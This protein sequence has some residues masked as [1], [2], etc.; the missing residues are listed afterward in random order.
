[1]EQIKIIKTGEL[2]YSN[3]LGGTGPLV[4][5]AG[6]VWIYRFLSWL[7]FGTENVPLGQAFFGWLYVGTL[8]IVF[9]IYLRLDVPPWVIY[10]LVLSKRLH[11]I[12]VLRLFNDCFTTFFMVLTVVSL[13]HAS[14]YRQQNKRLARILTNQVSAV[15]FG[16]AISIKMNALLYLPGFCVVVYFLN[17]EVLIRALV[18]LVVVGLVQVL[19]SWNFLF[20]GSEIRDSYIANAFDFK[21][22]F[23]YEWT[24]NWR[25]FSA[26]IFNSNTFHRALLGIHVVL[27]ILF[28][29]NK[30]AAPYCSGKSNKS[31]ITDLFKIFKPTISPNHVIN[32]PTSGPIYVVGVMASCNLIG[33]LCSRSL[34][35]QFLS[36]YSWSFPYLLYLSN[37]PWFLSIAVFILHEW[38]W[39]VFPSTKLSSALLLVINSAVLGGYY[40]NSR[41]KCD[42]LASKEEKKEK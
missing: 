25:F 40:F 23:L 30:W 1:M 21:R 24:V 17:D 6:H 9:G 12:Y 35:Y 38:C 31:L 26:D 2:N 10:L 41:G 22:K 33:V 36:W 32:N 7:T 27:L 16:I 39:N 5:P 18:P 11:S 42:V 3:I 20:S 8:L 13:Q 29:F 15:L 19:I 34:H 37:L 14:A 28:T 4:Y